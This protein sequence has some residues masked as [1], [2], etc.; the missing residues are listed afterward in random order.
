M[1]SGCPSESSDEDNSDTGGG[2]EESDDA[3]AMQDD[4]DAD[5]QAGGNGNSATLGERVVRAVAQCQSCLYDVA[6]MP[7]KVRAEGRESGLPW[8]NITGRGPPLSNRS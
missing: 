8:V 2:E 6:M 3:D 1:G 7:S 4:A 5:G